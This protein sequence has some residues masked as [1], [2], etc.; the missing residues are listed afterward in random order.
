MQRFAV[1]KKMISHGISR[2]Y[3]MTFFELNQMNNYGWEY[4]IITGNFEKTFMLYETQ[5]L[6]YMNRENGI[7]IYYYIYKKISCKVLSATITR[8]KP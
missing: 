7:H 8:E 6:F 4:S 3:I 2:M 1:T 5:Y